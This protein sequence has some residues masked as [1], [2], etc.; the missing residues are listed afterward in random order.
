L[1]WLR[2]NSHGCS[3]VPDSNFALHFLQ[4]TRNP[5]MEQENRTSHMSASTH[6]SNL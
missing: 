6:L 5:K 2:I 1:S 4:S 3:P